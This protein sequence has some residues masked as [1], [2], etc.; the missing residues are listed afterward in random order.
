MALKFMWGFEIGAGIDYYANSGWGIPL[1]ADATGSSYALYDP[2]YYEAHQPPTNVGGGSRCLKQTSYYQHHTVY[3]GDVGDLLAFSGTYSEVTTPVTGSPGWMTTSG[4]VHFSF[5]HDFDFDQDITSVSNPLGK[6]IHLCTLSSGSAT[7]SMGSHN[8]FFDGQLLNNTVGSDMWMPLSNTITVNSSHREKGYRPL[9]PI[10]FY[11]VRQSGN[12]GPCSGSG[13]AIVA[14]L[15]YADGVG[16]PA[17]M[18]FSSSIGGV[19]QSVE[20]EKDIWTKFTILYKGSDVAGKVKVWQDGVLKMNESGKTRGTT[21]NKFWN[22]VTFSPHGKYATRPA[23]DFPASVWPEYSQL[24]DH[25]FI[26]DDIKNPADIRQ[27]TS[28]LFIQGLLPNA[29][30][31]DGHFYNDIGTQMALFKYINDPGDPTELEA[32]HITARPTPATLC[33][34]NVQTKSQIE[35]GALIWNDYSAQI[36][37]IVAV[38]SVGAC[39]K[40]GVVG[41][42]NYRGSTIVGK[43]TAEEIG[44]SVIIERDQLVWNF[45]EIDVLV[46]GPW[47][48][49]AIGS[50]K[51]GFK[52]EPE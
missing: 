8:P 22:S 25:I 5:K 31:T 51:V 15:Y 12:D 3:P 41:S 33:K 14:I 30:N 13:D 32:S 49:A 36:K 29:D 9:A 35:N 1:N 44:P 20:I 37:E 2:Q 19:Q 24:V 42:S 27:S 38:G 34:F 48:P 52:V 10:S 50:L 46:G 43:L 40:A 28:S 7:S 6:W 45:S 18:V 23:N 26:W 17:S 4:F 11:L 16:D 47:D 39:T 21:A